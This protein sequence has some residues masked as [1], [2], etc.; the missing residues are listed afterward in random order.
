MQD[1]SKRFITIVLSLGVIA[2]LAGI[3]LGAREGGRVLGRV[4]QS[5]LTS[6]PPISVTPEPQPTVTGIY[7]PDWKSSDVLTV[8]TDPGFPD[9]R[10]PPVPLPTARPTPKKTPTPLPAASPTPTPNL[11]LP[12]WRRLAPLPTASPVGSPP[13]SASPEPGSPLPSSSPP[14]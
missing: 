14:A 7:G 10:V 5:Q 13:S 12:I 2:L 1:P 6:L 4:T 8:P 11:N 3:A 9:P